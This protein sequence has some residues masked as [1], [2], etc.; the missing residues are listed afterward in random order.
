MLFD[1]D[2]VVFTAKDAKDLAGITYRM[3][4][5]W[6]AKG[7]LASAQTSEGS[8]RRF[9]PRQMLALMVCSAIRRQYRVPIESLK[10]VMDSMLRKGANHCQWAVHTIV[11]YEWTIYLLTDLKETFI[12]DC[13]Y[14]FRFFI[15]K[16]LFR[17][18]ESK[19]FV[20]L[21]MNDLVDAVLRAAGLDPLKRSEIFYKSLRDFERETH[22]FHGEDISERERELLRLL[23]SK[24]DQRLTIKVEGGVIVRADVD[25]KI[26]AFGSDT[27][28]QIQEALNGE[29]F[30]T[31]KIV[32]RGGRFVGKERRT[33]NRLDG[34]REEPDPK[35]LDALNVIVTRNGE[36]P[37]DGRESA[38]PREESKDAPAERVQ[39]DSGS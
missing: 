18:V 12:F 20:F 9:T 33:P 1:D 32:K 29:D 34:L 15:Q 24:K 4:S 28:A 38:K 27:D 10:F 3:L 13:D 11:K 30:A 22:E 6:D 2:E 8:W 23:R 35:H 25:E 21:R 19:S 31:L 7:V 16:G 39:E 14:N 26:A 17:Q 5:D 37:E 36:H